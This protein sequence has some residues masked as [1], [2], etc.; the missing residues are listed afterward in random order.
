LKAETVL[1]VEDLSVSYQVHGGEVRALDG[2]SLEIH[3]GEIVAVVGES[4]CGKTTLAKAVLGLQSTSQ[5]RITLM[6]E[7]VTGTS[8]NMATKV[9]M[10]WQDPYASLN[11]RWMI[12]R[13][14][15]EPAVLAGQ[16]I[17]TSKLISE[18]GLDSRF[19]ERFPHE[20]SGG[21]RQRVAIGRAISLEPPLIICDEPT[22]ALDLSIRAQ[23]LNL[24]KD[25]RE[26]KGCAFLYIS[27]D[28]TTV[29]FLAD[30]IMVMYMGR[31]VEAGPTEQ[32][33]SR[34]KHPYTKAL[35]DSAP[36][37]DKL[38]F[39]P[40]PLEG[41]LPDPKL[42]IAGCRFA[43]RCVRKV[44]DCTIEDPSATIEGERTF[45]CHNPN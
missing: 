6:G 38:M 13:S 36:T 40:E 25:I 1:T 37:L 3:K 42:R 22:S 26:E 19:S 15:S 16:S 44:N 35:L 29:R 34:P 23:I 17:D 11:P 2:V 7:P 41:E 8:R 39:L 14:M 20:L 5:G 10:V 32:I 18:V 24:L 45:F 28:L 4:G 43:S 21:Q 27:H 30:R 31:I 12:S 33:F 9:G